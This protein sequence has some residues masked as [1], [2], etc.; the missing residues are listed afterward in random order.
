MPLVKR[1]LG[2]A[3]KGIAV[4]HGIGGGAPGA[5]P[6]FLA[7]G[8]IYFES[9]EAFQSSFGPHS[10]EIVADVANYTNVQP[11]LQISEVKM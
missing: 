9:V 11:V 3:V 4:E 5:A 2:A 7:M 8:H 10:A 1:L 6:Q